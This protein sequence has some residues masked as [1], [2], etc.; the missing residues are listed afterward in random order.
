MKCSLSG[1]RSASGSAILSLL[2]RTCLS[3]KIA[4]SHN[5]TTAVGNSQALGQEQ[6]LLPRQKNPLDS[7]IAA[8]KVRGSKDLM[9]V[10][11]G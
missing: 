3:H 6:R 10:P 9:Y 2:L 4:R 7:P 1:R 11:V 5:N 8:G